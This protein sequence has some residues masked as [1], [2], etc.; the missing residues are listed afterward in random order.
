MDIA[1]LLGNELAKKERTRASMSDSEEAAA[2]AKTRRVLLVEDDA[3][4]AELI[5]RAF[6]ATGMT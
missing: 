6:D 5:R 3:A 2:Q 4:H 1:Y